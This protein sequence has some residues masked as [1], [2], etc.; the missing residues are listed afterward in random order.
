MKILNKTLPILSILIYLISV[1]QNA[2]KVED[3]EKIKIYKSYEV[4]LMGGIG[5]LG[6]GIFEAF[7]W[8]SNIWLLLALIFT[9]N[10]KYTEALI[11]SSLAT[12]IST[13]FILWN[14]VLASESGRNAKIISLELGYFL[15]ITSII[16]LFLNS[17]FSFLKK[18]K[19]Q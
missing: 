1:T 12:L 10:K 9:K 16:I 14:E 3:L 6:G 13:S 17:I 8:S 11:F 2:F 5:F 15:W 19:L 18:K 4:L 7:I